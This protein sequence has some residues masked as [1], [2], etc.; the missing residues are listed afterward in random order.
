MFD[1]STEKKSSQYELMVQVAKLYYLDD[2]SQQE[3]AHR[4]NMSR[5][6]ISRVLKACRENGIVEIRIH[7]QSM[8]SYEISKKLQERFYLNNLIVTPHANS[9]EE[10]LENV[11]RETAR[12]LKGLLHDGMTVGLGWGATVYRMVRSFAPQNFHNVQVVQLMGGSRIRETYK[13]GV[14]LTIDFAEK[15]G[16]APLLLNAPLLVT[17]KKVRDILIEEAG[18]KEQLEMADKIDVAVATIGTNLPEKSAMVQ[19]DFISW[20]ESQQLC[21]DGLY[22]HILGQHIDYNGTLGNT[23]LNDRVVGINLQTFRKIPTKIGTATG[24]SKVPAIVCALMGGYFDTLI[25]D[26]DTALKVEQY[27][28]QRGLSKH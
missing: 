22:A 20:E 5:S 23:K 7:E 28:A 4:V 21:D 13:D 26:E 10:N 3:I 27:A 24:D 25:T 9:G 2:L 19:A 18:I 12:Y 11:G 6:N 14:Q 16:G 17:S 8:R 15:T 1:L